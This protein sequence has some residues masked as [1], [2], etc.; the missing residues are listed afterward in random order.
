[1]LEKAKILCSEPTRMGANLGFFCYPSTYTF[2]S[3]LSFIDLLCCIVAPRSSVLRHNRTRIFPKSLRTR[4]DCIRPYR[5][6]FRN[7]EES[8]EMADFVKL[9]IF[10]TVSPAP[11]STSARRALLVLG[12]YPLAASADATS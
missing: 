1:M 8:A 7:Q 3:L 9:S 10:G 12:T 4:A 11:P 6:Y 5:T 2:L